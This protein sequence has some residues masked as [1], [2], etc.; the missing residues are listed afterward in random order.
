MKTFGSLLAVFA[1]AAATVLAFAGTA[2]ADT[3]SVA[4]ADLDGDHRID[5]V[6]LT[7]NPDN[8][9]EQILVGTVN[10]TSYVTRMPIP[11]GPGLGVFPLRVVDLDRDGRQEVVVT[12]MVGASTSWFGVWYL[13]KPGAGWQPLQAESGGGFELYEG[14]GVREISGYGCREAGGHRELVLLSAEIQD[15]WEDGI[16][17]GALV[18][19]T[20]RDG[21]AR[22]TS[23]TTVS[24]DRGTLTSMAI[25]SNCV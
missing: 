5:R 22:W 11:G 7:Q 15:P 25:S 9:N 21:V 24:G 17:A 3:M 4:Y 8:P 12:E 2:S 13:G 20:V 14:G 1:T 10:R 16:Y 19:Y 23:G 18:A 6:T